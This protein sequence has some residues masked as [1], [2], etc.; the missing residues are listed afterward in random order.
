M[1]TPTA[2]MTATYVV[3]HPTQGVYV[4]RPD[5]P[6]NAKIEVRVDTADEADALAARFPK[7]VAAK[8][9]RV[10]GFNMDPYHMVIIKA[11]LIATGTT[12]DVNEAGI[13]RVR[14]AV[15]VL[16]ADG[17]AI[18]WVGGFRNSYDTREEAAEAIGM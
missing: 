15:A 5:M 8:T 13:K 2:T 3:Q 1:T 9:T 12:G 18:E 11:R 14:R 10:T 4:D 6:Q 16:D 17:I 7:Y